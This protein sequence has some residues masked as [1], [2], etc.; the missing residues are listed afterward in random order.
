MSALVVLVDGEIQSP[1]TSLE[2][3]PPFWR[4]LASI[5]HAALI[6]REVL[7]AE[8]EPTVF[9]DWA[10]EEWWGFLLHAIIG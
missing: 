6:E 8:L 10:L 4:R 2:Q 7:D 5:A 9:S 3:R 1:K